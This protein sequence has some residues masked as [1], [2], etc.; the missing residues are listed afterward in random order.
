MRPEAVCGVTKDLIKVSTDFFC[1]GVS[2]DIY[3]FNSVLI[4]ADAVMFILK[5]YYCAAYHS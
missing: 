2:N 4:E 5:C 1:A 3:L